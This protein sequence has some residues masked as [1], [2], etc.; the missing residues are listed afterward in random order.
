MQSEEVSEGA[1]DCPGNGSPHRE[2]GLQSGETGD[3]RPLSLP[4]DVCH[5]ATRS[6]VAPLDRPLP[7]LCP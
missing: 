5:V 1:V 2:A 3:T 4:A 6:V 7:T